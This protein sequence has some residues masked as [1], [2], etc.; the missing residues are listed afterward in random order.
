[1]RSAY[2]AIAAGSI[3]SSHR[4]K[5]YNVLTQCTL[6]PHL[7]D[8]EQRA[9]RMFDNLVDQMGKQEGIT[10]Q[11]KAE[12]MTLWLRKMNIVRKQAEEIVNHEI[13]FN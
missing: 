4:V 12:D 11:L 9:Q 6:Y 2:G 13:I 1:M 10:E 8:V 3:L 7:A 5:Y